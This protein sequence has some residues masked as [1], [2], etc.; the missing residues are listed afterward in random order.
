M[1]AISTPPT[2]PRK[3]T[4]LR[5]WMVQVLEQ[6]DKVAVDFSPDFVHDLRVAL[7]RFRSMADGL[8]ALDPAPAW[9]EMKKAGKRLFQRLGDLR[10]IHVMEEWIEKLHPAEA[11]VEQARVEGALPSA[12]SGQA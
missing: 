5:Y 3:N 7:R 10:D 11:S 1:P 6:C 8:M 4:G 12:S 9:K 2:R